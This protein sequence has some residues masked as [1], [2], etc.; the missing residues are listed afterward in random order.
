MKAERDEIVAFRL[1]AHHLTERLDEHGLL[2]AAACGVQNSPPGSALLALNARVRSV[3]PQSLDAAV[4]D[5]SMLQT[6]A[7][8][9]APFFFPTVD[10][11]IFTAGVLPMTEA[12]LRR[13]ILGIGPSVDDLGITVTE[14]VD[15]VGGHL[16]E[17][18]TGRRLAVDDLGAELARLVVP[19]LTPAQREVRMREGPHA[20]GQPVGEAVAHFCLRV[21][22]LRGRVC[23][24]PRDGDRAPFVLVEEWLGHP[25]PA[26]D[27]QRVR[28]ELL[29]RYLHCYGP[30]T[31]A[32]FAGWIGV[33]AG[34][35]APWWEL[36]EGELV[37]VDTGR[38]AWMLATDVHALRTA[39]LPEGVRL[40]PPRD[41]YTQARDRGILVDPAHQREVWKTVGDPG[42]LLVDGEIAGVWRPR[43]KGRMLTITVSP[44]A[45]LTDR[46]QRL[47][48]AE[49][50]QVALLRGAATVDVIVA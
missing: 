16:G 21:L 46:M 3:T 44:F 33:R 22:M 1:S 40:L 5:R 2:A 4:D 32:D 39:A 49:A 15:L 34:D 24:A 11:A 25:L 43:K 36:L 28:G 31:R 17:A 45:A 35:V 20:D 47:L 7:M 27:P 30:S 48:Q 14:A 41:P 6:W 23:F 12:A 42:A 8:R 13:F 29:R 37:E 9:G 38:R 19:D 10:A 50:E 26:A 18:L